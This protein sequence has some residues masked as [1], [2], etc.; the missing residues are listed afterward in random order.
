MPEKTRQPP[1]ARMTVVEM[2][3][4]A[5]LEGINKVVF[6]SEVPESPGRGV[7]AGERG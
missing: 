3:W 4:D 5:S 7:I 2:I 6:N 1:S